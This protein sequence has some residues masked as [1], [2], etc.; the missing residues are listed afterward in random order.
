MTIV[1]SAPV[2]LNWLIG[3]MNL[4]EASE[5]SEIDLARDKRGEAVHATYRANLSAVLG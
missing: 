5:L 1:A 4:D 3:C 2:A